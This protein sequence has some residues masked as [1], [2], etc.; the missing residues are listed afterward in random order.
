MFDKVTAYVT[1]ETIYPKYVKIHV[2]AKMCT[3]VFIAFIAT[4]FIIAK[5]E[6]EKKPMSINW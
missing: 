2:Y 5:N 3:Q 4:L 6:G 1:R